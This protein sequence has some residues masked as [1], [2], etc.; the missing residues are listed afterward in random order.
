[1]AI[2]EKTATQVL[3]SIRTKF[4]VDPESKYGPELIHNYESD[5]RTHEWAIIWEGPYDWDM[6]ACFQVPIPDGIFLESINH[7]SVAIY[8]V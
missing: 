6:V 8:P 4:D 5:Y 1:M 2:S 7:W 3:E